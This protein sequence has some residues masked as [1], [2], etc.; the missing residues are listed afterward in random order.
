[1]P[2][3]YS[4]E[5]GFSEILSSRA[6]LAL[7][8]GEKKRTGKIRWKTTSQDTTQIAPCSARCSRRFR[9]SVSQ[10]LKTTLQPVHYML[11]ETLVC[12]RRRGVPE[13]RWLAP[14]R[15]RST[16]TDQYMYFESLVQC[17]EGYLGRISPRFHQIRTHWLS[18]RAERTCNGWRG[19]A[20][21]RRRQLVQA[22]GF[23]HEYNRH[24]A[25]K[26]VPLLRS[27]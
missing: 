15:S 5:T 24:D 21:L 8:S 20:N 4:P 11:M 13:K 3:R 22:R 7:R 25:T 2:P 1:M 12:R 27:R 6:R 19:H 26:K 10:L 9:S 18:R 17:R 16:V 14:V 23:L